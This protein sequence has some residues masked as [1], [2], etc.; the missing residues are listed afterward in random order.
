M[1]EGIIYIFG[2]FVSNVGGWI[3]AVL[4]PVNLEWCKKK[5]KQKNNDEYKSKENVNWKDLAVDLK[6]FWIKKDNKM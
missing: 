1:L 3:A 6:I 5:K 4:E 2:M